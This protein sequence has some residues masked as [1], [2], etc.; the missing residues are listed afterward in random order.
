MTME[1]RAMPTGAAEPSQNGSGPAAT[2]D[3]RDYGVRIMQV[4]MLPL[5]VGL[6]HIAATNHWI[7]PLLA[8]TPLQIWN[9][10][11][12]LAVTGEL[13][14]HLYATMEA[15]FIAFV[16]ASVVG[17]FAGIMLALMPRTERVLSPYFDALNSMP[18][19][20]LAP[21]FLIYF[22][23][24]TSAKVAL[25]FSL[26]VFIVMGN[27]RAGVLSAD[28]D[29]LRLTTILGANKRQIFTK[30]YLPVA[31]PA[32]FAGLRL[33]LIYSLLGVVGS[34]LIAA[35]EGLG[36][37][38]AQFSGVFEMEGVYGVLIILAIIATLLNTAMRMAERYILRW[39]PEEA[40]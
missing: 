4:L 12:A 5:L 17:V 19:I 27:A 9:S 21:V 16:L 30:V 6:W 26:V 11:V 22:G 13:W 34:E 35:R 8:R 23:I 36:M 1:D 7:N 20:A 37:L 2:P 24:G 25:A 15:V 14:R 18:R 33:G 38:V 29:V 31:T 28:A 39:Q 40:K 3:R 32:I 10:M